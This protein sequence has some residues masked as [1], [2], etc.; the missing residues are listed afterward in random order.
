MGSRARPSSRPGSTARPRTPGNHK[1]RSARPCGQTLAAPGEPA[2]AQQGARPRRWP[3]RTHA[4]PPGGPMPLANRAARLTAAKP[5]RNHQLQP[6]AEPGPARSHATGETPVPC[7]WRTTSGGRGFKGCRFGRTPCQPRSLPAELPPV[8][9]TS[10]PWRFTAGSQLHPVRLSLAVPIS[11]S[12]HT[13]PWRA[14]L[15]PGRRAVT[16]GNGTSNCIGH[17]R[18]PSA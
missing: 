10:V 17:S 4:A 1:A 9:R 2:A 8:V 18:L 15:V 12:A 16:G 7:S 5:S 6:T 3:S 11:I 14:G 13:A